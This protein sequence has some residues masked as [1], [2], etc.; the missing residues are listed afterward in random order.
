MTQ[1]TCYDKLKSTQDVLHRQECMY[2]ANGELVCG[3]QGDAVSVILGEK[4]SVGPSGSQAQSQA[5]KD[6]CVACGNKS[7][8]IGSGKLLP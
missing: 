5:V 7:S 4:C 8:G 1:K 2:A 6:G 3:F